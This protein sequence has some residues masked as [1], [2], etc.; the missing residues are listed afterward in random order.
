[1]HEDLKLA[2]RKMGYRPMPAKTE[3]ETR[4]KVWGKPVGYSIM[5][6]S[7]TDEHGL[8]W[9]QWFWHHRDDKPILWSRKQF[10]ELRDDIEYVVDFY[11]G[12]IKEYENWDQKAGSCG[13]FPGT[14]EFLTLSQ[15]ISL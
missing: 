5:T 13:P 1:M 4:A 12:W 10:P 7:D 6:I 9:S 8:E 14:F 11:S 3:V 15:S 2:M